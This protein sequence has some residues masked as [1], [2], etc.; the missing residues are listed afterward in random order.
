MASRSRA[1]L[2][3]LLPKIKGEAMTPEAKEAL[4][5]TF[6]TNKCI[7]NR[8]NRGLYAGRHIQFGNQISEDGGNK[9]RRK[10]KPNVQEKRLFSLILDRHIRIKV[11]THAI[12]CIDKAGGID[13]YLLQTNTRKLDN[14]LALHWKAKIQ[15]EYKEL[16]KVE[17]GFFPP[18]EEKKLEEAFERLKIARKALKAKNRKAI[19]PDAETKTEGGAEAEV[20]DS[21]LENKDGAESDVQALGILHIFYFC[22][23]IGVPTAWQSVSRVQHLTLRS[24]ALEIKWG[25]LAIMLNAKL[26]GYANCA[27]QEFP[28]SL[29]LLALVSGQCVSS[30]PC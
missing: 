22:D 27:F 21:S 14:E 19:S 18:E 26:D 24:L 25:T 2:K 15:Q 9:T 6:P 11:T 17:V 1:M 8:A 20:Q 16:S 23:L 12:R 28:G 4:R 30:K 29:G 5:R 13:E 10:W 7:M 3:K